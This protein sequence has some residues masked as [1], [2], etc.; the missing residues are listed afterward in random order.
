[1]EEFEKLFKEI[2]NLNE[3]HKKE[4]LFNGFVS[5]G[6]RADET[7]HSKFIANLLN[8]KGNHKQ[9]DKFLKLFLEQVEITDFNLKGLDVKCEKDAKG[10]RIDIA[11]WNKTQFLVIENKFWAGDQDNQLRDY[12]NFALKQAK[13][14]NIIMLYLTPYGKLP[15]P[16]SLGDLSIEDVICISYEKHIL[17]W[18]NECLDKFEATDNIRLKIS[19]EMY[20]ELIR[21]VINRDKYMEEIFEFINKEENLNL[22]ISII[23]SL[24]GRNLM[25]SPERIQSFKRQIIELAPDCGID[26]PNQDKDSKY[27]LEIALQYGNDDKLIG[28]I[29]YDKSEIFLCDSMSNPLNDFKINTKVIS[30]KNLQ[31]LLINNTSEIMV[32]LN[33]IVSKFKTLQK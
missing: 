21:I 28:S 14:E 5:F 24:E 32:W 13:A 17:N 33:N 6:I 25:D 29:C 30:D 18:L 8:P 23:N 31:N 27:E 12:Y 3:K 2:S 15:S 26:N 11:I 19:L 22:A 10:R 20:A 4:D 16:D 7:K 1:M 9:G